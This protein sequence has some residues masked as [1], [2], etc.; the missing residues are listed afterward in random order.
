MC[1][2]LCSMILINNTNRFELFQLLFPLALASGI[3]SIVYHW[4]LISYDRRFISN[5]NH[6]V[7]IDEQLAESDS[8]AKQTNKFFLIGNLIFGLALLAIILKIIQFNLDKITSFWMVFFLFLYA[9][10]GLIVV[11]DA[12][13]KWRESWINTLLNKS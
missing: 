2:Q 6:E 3:I 7:I 1:C 8:K 12:I 13:K 10:V 11:Q 5:S 9:L 4:K